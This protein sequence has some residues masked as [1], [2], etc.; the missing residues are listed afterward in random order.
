MKTEGRLRWTAGVATLLSLISCYGSLALIAGLGALGISVALNEAVWA[1]AI[2]LFAV[3][4]IV[5]LAF[6]P[7]RHGRH[8]PLVIG[9][10]GAAALV[11]AMYVSYSIG[12]EL[13][14]F[15]LLVAATLSDLRFRRSVGRDESRI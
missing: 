9:G 14:G 4:A 5:G 1:G 13:T 7:S 15:V 12:I 3:L 8:G 6:G 2:V 11:Y 10:L